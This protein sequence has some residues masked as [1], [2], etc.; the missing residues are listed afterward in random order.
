MSQDKA[1]SSESE[2]QI[3]NRPAG[4]IFSRL[5]NAPRI[6]EEFFRPPTRHDAANVTGHQADAPALARF[7]DTVAIP[8]RKQG[9]VGEEGPDFRGGRFEG[10]D[11]T[12]RAF[13]ND[14][15]F[16][17]ESF[18]RAAS[19]ASR[20]GFQKARMRATQSETSSTPLG[21]RA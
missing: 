16:H 1:R 3:G 9:A 4:H 8:F 19:K 6:G 7:Y 18:F 12:H 21:S 17:L 2:F 14:F 5:E 20:R 10:A 15:A 11:E 13:G